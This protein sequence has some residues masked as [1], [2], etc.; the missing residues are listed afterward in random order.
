MATFV[1]IVVVP[2][3]PRGLWTAAGHGDAVRRNDAAQVL[4]ALEPEQQ[5]LDTGLELT[6][7]EW[8]DHHVVCT[9]LEEPNPLLDIVRLAD[10]QDRDGGERRRRADLATHLDRVLRAGHDVEDHDLVIGN[11]GERLVRIR[12]RSDRV[13]GACQDA[14]DQRSRRLVG[15]DEQNRAGGHR[16]SAGMDI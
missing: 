13:A 15:A 2:T 7:V 16:A 12:D 5:R 4:R 8:L 14:G 6:G 11:S 10:A 9:G 1:A 3:P